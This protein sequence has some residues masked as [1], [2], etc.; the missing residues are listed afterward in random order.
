MLAHARAISFTDFDQTCAI[1]ELV[2]YIDRQ[3]RDLLRLSAGFRHYGDDI[4]ERA[5]ELFDEIIADDVLILVPPNLCSDQQQPS[6]RLCQNAVRL[7]A[8]RPEQFRI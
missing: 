1:V 6:A 3:S 8:R 4:C 7:P 5:S 2:C